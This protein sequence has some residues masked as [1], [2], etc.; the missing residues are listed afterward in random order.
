MQIKD[1]ALKGTAATPELWGA[2]YMLLVFALLARALRAWERYAGRPLGWQDWIAIGVDLLICP[3]PL[4]VAIAFRRLVT[5][6]LGNSGIN[7]RTYK[8]CN[9]RIA[10]LLVFTYI[11]MVL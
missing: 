8:M 4:L 6:E 3:V 7:T 9:Y 5:R 10:E 11:T 2:V 1:R